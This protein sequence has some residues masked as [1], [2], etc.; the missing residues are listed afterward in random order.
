M[1]QYLHFRILKFPLKMGK[2]EGFFL[3]F[4]KKSKD[5]NKDLMGMLS[6]FSRKREGNLR[7]WLI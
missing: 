1:V 5:I 7:I 3:E 2:P 4:N 6:D